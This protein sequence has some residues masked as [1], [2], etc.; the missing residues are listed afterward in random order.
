MAK[1]TK[2]QVLKMNNQLF[3]GFMT[4]IQKLLMRE[5]VA[6]KKVKLDDKNYLLAS[7]WFGVQYENYKKISDTIELNVSLYT[8]DSVNSEVSVS[9][10]LGYNETLETGLTRKTW[11][12][13]AS[14]SQHIDDDYILDLHNK[15]KAAMKISR[16]V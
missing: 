2:E 1:V 3:N 11:K 15:H 9:H 10:G 8:K 14:H 5:K 12:Q 13:L 6:I 7:L 4:D 16:I